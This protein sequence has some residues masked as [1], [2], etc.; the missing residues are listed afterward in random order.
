MTF[1]TSE[2]LNEKV[3]WRI[4]SHSDHEKQRKCGVEAIAI[5]IVYIVYL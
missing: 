5:Y 2:V 3:I 4:I 1:I